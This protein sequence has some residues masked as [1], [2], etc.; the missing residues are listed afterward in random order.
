M[1]LVF[2]HRQIG[3]IVLD[4][5]T[6]NPVRD[7]HEQLIRYIDL[8]SI[9]QDTKVIHPNKPIV[10]REAPSRARQL[11]HTGDVLVSTVRPN[12]NSVA[13]V[14][15]I[16]DG[17]TASTGFCVLRPNPKELDGAYL[18]HWVIYFTG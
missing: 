11:V 18:L 17:A 1:N 16:L 7:G 10:A 4:V 8:S 5:A 6:W 15:P 12:L 13:I 14:D 9:D 3:D 2:Q